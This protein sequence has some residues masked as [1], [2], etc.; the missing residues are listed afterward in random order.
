MFTFIEDSDGWETVRSR[1]R[2]RNSP[3]KKI[4]FSAEKNGKALDMAKLNQSRF[5][6]F[7]YTTKSSAKTSQN[8][9][10]TKKDEKNSHKGKQTKNET[11]S[12][13]VKNS[14][15]SVTGS[16]LSEK[17]SNKTVNASNLI[18]ES[19]SKHT[20]ITEKSVIKNEKLI[21]RLRAELNLSEEI[22][23]KISCNTFKSNL[24]SK[25]ASLPCLFIECPKNTFNLSKT[26]SISEQSLG[27][28]KYGKVKHCSRNSVER[29]FNS[30][31]KKNRKFSKSQESAKE[32]CTLSNSQDESDTGLT[33]DDQDGQVSNIIIYIISFF[34]CLLLSL[35]A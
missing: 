22:C 13:T 25:S 11:N 24:M 6:G 17:I 19:K 5:G 7:P 8:K 3:A 16:I 21:I 34:Q 15:N 2:C 31:R 32:D 14:S 4:P 20:E 29:S 26:K 30:T 35:F 12:L 28:K 18:N 33:S 1:N 10:V 23:S 9:L 27:V